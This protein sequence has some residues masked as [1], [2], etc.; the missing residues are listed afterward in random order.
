MPNLNHEVAPVFEK[1][2]KQAKKYLLE[3]RHLIYLAAADLN[4][5]D[6][7]E[8]LKWGEPSYLCKTGSTIRIDWKASTPKNAYIFFNCKSLLITTLKELY[9][10]DLIF[11][12][13]RAIILDINQP[14]KQDIIQHC[15]SLALNY[16]K[17]KTTPLLG[18]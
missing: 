15:F 14:I 18:C 5:K 7:N 2:P 13:N 10:D 8:T 9:P 11:Q 6:I 3:L 1:Y 4:I 12:S 16:H 17:L